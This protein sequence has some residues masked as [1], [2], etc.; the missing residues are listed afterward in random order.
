[1][2]DDERKQI[3]DKYGAPPV[4][5]L[6]AKDGLTI[7]VHESNPIEVLS[8]AQLKSVYT[9]ETTGWKALGGPDQPITVY[10]REN[11]SGTY[12]YFKDHVLG[13]ADFAAAVLTL[14]G[15]AAVVNAVAKDPRG[16]GYG[17]A[18]YATGVREVAVRTDETTPAVLP[19]AEFV[20]DGSYPNSRG[21]YFYMRK[22]PEGGIKTFV[23]YVLSEEGQSVVTEVG[24]FPIR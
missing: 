19:K 16:I 8:I 10:G 12:E 15:T 2:K 9:G 22:A 7:Y 4:E 24:Y 21:L 23:D 5:I 3:Q 18:A 17:G 14:P 13:G 11:S 6:V 1:M 20:R